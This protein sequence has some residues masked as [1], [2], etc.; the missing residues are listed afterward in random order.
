M[1][2]EELEWLYPECAGS[3]AVKDS[4]TSRQ[5]AGTS[6][7]DGTEIV[8]IYSDGSC[9]GNPG[10]GG[11]AVLLRQGADERQ[12]SGGEID[13]TNNQM[14]LMAAIQA[15]EAL[16]QPM[17]VR[18][19]VDSRY[20][21]DGITKW[22][23]NWKRNGWKTSSLKPVKNGD[24]WRRLDEEQARH[25]VEW[26]WVPGHAGN[27]DNERVDQLARDAAAKRPAANAAQGQLQPAAK[28]SSHAGMG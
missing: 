24:L 4:D 27:A 20:V 19:H 17:T 22:I 11:W 1:T 23:R 8:E 15:L 12:L 13:T 16:K 28:R 2:R 14:E 10:P 5:L 21:R 6:E 18:I 26:R 25:R 7:W 3:G 9:L